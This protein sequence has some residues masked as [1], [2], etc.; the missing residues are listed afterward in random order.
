VNAVQ[1]QLLRDALMARSS[2]GEGRQSLK[3]ER[4]VRFPYGLL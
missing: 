3:L 2:I 1:V 4:W